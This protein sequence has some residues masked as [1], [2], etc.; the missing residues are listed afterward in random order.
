LLALVP[1]HLDHERCYADGGRPWL[2]S[3]FGFDVVLGG[4][5]EDLR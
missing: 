5:L 2:A 4:E 3:G 1:A